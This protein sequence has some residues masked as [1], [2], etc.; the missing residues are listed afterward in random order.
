[1][2]RPVKKRGAYSTFSMRGQVYFCTAHAMEIPF[3]FERSHPEASFYR[4]TSTCI[5]ASSSSGVVLLPA[6][7]LRGQH[8]QASSWANLLSR[9]YLLK[10]PFFTQHRSLDLSSSEF[11]R[12]RG[13]YLALLLGLVP[14][15]PG[16]S[17][18][19]ATNSGFRRGF[20]PLARIRLLGGYRLSGR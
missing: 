20:S 17:L 13:A 1:M 5:S 14:P 4:S 7:C 10:G 11:H 8:L 3:L 9:L 18:S 6:V 15:T 12:Y 19:P 16:Y 2:A